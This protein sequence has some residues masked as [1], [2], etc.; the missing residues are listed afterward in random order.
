MDFKKL[1]WDW[2]PNAEWDLLKWI[3]KQGAWASMIATLVGFV[4]KIR[5]GAL[6]WW[7]LG[8]VFVASAFGLFL[9]SHRP[10][11]TTIPVAGSLPLSTQDAAIRERINVLFFSCGQPAY[12]DIQQLTNRLCRR[13]TTD[14]D[15]DLRDPLIATLAGNYA[16]APC[17]YASGAMNRALNGSDALGVGM[18]QQRLSEFIKAYRLHVRWMHIIGPYA[19]LPPLNEDPGY[20]IWQ[21]KHKLFRQELRR[22][23]ATDDFAHLQQEIEG[24]WQDTWGADE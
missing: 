10:Q 6:D 22:L 7:V 21:E 23:A 17:N 20:D 8:T 3:I 2:I 9:T 13:F 12:F 16:F 11:P 15:R 24:G 1:L 5:S 18:L 14:P 19:P 4:E